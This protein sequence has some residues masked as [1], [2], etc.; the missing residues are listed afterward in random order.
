M[1]TVKSGLRMSSV[2]YPRSDLYGTRPELLR[3]GFL[4][5]EPGSISRFL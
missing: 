2:A 1:K 4:G 5:L 3:V